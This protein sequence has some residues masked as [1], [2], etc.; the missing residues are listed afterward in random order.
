MPG[1]LPAGWTESTPGGMA[2]SADPI[3]GGIVD[4]A[5]VS[6][7]WF[8]IFNREDVAPLEGFATREA[9]FAA[10]AARLKTVS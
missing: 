10:F 5:M 6:G 4:T 3:N 7:E 1:A 2:A 9:A 8:V